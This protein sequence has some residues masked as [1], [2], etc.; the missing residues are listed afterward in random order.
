VSCASHAPK[1][2]SAEWNAEGWTA[3][4]ADARRRH[5]IAY[6]CEHCHERRSPIRRA[7]G[8]H[9][10]SVELNERSGFEVPND[11]EVAGAEAT[12][13]VHEGSYPRS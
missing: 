4:A 2:G 8:A 11:A 5:G 7:S 13:G 6:Q 10:K 1:E 12:D 9:A 3:I